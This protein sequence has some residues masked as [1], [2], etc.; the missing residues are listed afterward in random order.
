MQ[1]KEIPIGGIDMSRLKDG[2]IRS[3]SGGYGISGACK[4]GMIID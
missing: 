1:H 2:S 4:Q 3:R